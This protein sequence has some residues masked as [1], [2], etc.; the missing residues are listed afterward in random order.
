MA[1]GRRRDRG[2]AACLNWGCF[3]MANASCTSRGTVT[4]GYS[5]RN[6]SILGHSAGI[7]TT[8][9]AHISGH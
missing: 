8:G 2:M 3:I 5:H 9:T 6:E 4:T 7:T 1:R